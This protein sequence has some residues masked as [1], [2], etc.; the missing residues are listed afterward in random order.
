MNT[1]KYWAQGALVRELRFALCRASADEMREH[2]QI[3]IL[4]WNEVEVLV[5]ERWEGAMQE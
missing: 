3:E 2:T 5:G 1:E 4:C